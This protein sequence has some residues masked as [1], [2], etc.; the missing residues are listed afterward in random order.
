MVSEALAVT[1]RPNMRMYYGL[2]EIRNIQALQNN[3]N[4]HCRK[5]V[6]SQNFMYITVFCAEEKLHKNQ[7]RNAHIEH[8]LLKPCLPTDNNPVDNHINMPSMMIAQIPMENKD[9]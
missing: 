2:F 7:E 8:I 9:S 5:T 3:G 6:C 1:T 4:N